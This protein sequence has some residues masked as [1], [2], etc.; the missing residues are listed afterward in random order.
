MNFFGS[1][2][3]MW[4]RFR[5][6][7]GQGVRV[8]LP[9]KGDMTPTLVQQLRGNFRIGDKDSNKNLNVLALPHCIQ[10]NLQ[11]QAEEHTAVNSLLDD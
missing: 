4:E 6:P 1:F 10:N 9:N 2:W 5:T 3:T 11:E 7:A 8:N